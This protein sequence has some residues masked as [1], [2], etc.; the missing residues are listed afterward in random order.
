MFSVVS[1]GVKSPQILRSGE[2]GSIELDISAFPK[3]K[4]FW[5]LNGIKLSLFLTGRRF[6]DPYTGS[7]RITNVSRIDAGNYTCTV[8]WKSDTAHET[9]D[10]VEIEV[11]V[12]GKLTLEI[13]IYQK[14]CLVA[15]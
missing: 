6:I 1:H 15:I 14:T 11:F 5:S 3:P 4:Y 10:T 2:N 8:R 7:L 13:R 9:E 12:A